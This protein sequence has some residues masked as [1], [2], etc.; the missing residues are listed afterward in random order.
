VHIPVTFHHIRFLP[1]QA[2]VE[3]PKSSKSQ[4]NI[5][6]AKAVESDNM[7]KHIL[8]QG[9]QEKS[10]RLRGGLKVSVEVKVM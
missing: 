10:R 1:P 7:E 9:E 2:Q 8:T 6:V 3:K 5:K 4:N